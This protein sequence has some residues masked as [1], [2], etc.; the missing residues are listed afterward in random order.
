LRRGKTIRKELLIV[1]WYI[2]SMNQKIDLTPFTVI[3]L[4]FGK[5]KR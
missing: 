2:L 1:Y 4:T 5:I 3:Y